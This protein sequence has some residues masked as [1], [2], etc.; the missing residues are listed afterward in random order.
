M[1][2]M[3]S[4]CSMSTGHWLTQAPQV[5]QDQRTS[6]SMTPYIDSSTLRGRSSWARAPS[7]GG[8][9]RRPRLHRVVARRHDQQLGRERLLGVPGRAL[10]LAAAALGAGGEVEQALPREVADRADAEPGVVVEIL[11]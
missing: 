9:H 11:D 3:W 4:T 7:M 1:S 5:V 10:R 2:T 8:D 6:G